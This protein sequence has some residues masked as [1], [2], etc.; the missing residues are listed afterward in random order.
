MGVTEFAANLR[1][2]HRWVTH[3]GGECIFV[4]EHVPQ[5]SEAYIPGNGQSYAENYEPYLMVLRESSSALN[6][7]LIDLP[8]LL[9][10]R[11]LSS[12]DI[13]GKDGL[14]LTAQG[15]AVYAELIFPALVAGLKLR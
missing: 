8:G 10:E 9:A 2:I 14:H 3:L 4:A 6:S 11:E 15:N 5:P 13:V 12:A 7:P 1:E